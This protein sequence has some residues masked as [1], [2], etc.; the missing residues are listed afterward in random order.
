MM[1]KHHIGSPILSMKSY[2]QETL[3]RLEQPVLMHLVIYIS[4]GIEKRDHDI[5]RE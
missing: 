5:E 1:E 2:I 4:T 3:Y